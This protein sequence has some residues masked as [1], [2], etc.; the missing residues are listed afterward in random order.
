MEVNTGSDL[1]NRL[2]GLCS[3]SGSAKVAVSRCGMTQF[4]LLGPRSS[5]TAKFPSA[6]RSLRFLGISRVCETRRVLSLAGPRLSG[7][8]IIS[9]G[10]SRQ[11]PALATQRR[12][13][14]GFREL[15]HITVAR[16][17]AR[18]PCRSPT[19]Q[20]VGDV[21]TIPLD[22]LSAYIANKYLKRMEMEP[23]IE[24][25]ACMSCRKC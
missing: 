8:V 5:H 17:S 21:W 6:S 4:C 13:D 22:P 15:G 24:P 1:Q 3:S 10:Q 12:Q 2:L 25:S 20:L 9:S 11:L 14:K 23:M 19:P 7:V 18:S 16:M